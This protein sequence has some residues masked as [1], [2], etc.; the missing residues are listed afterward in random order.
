MIGIAV[1][2]IGALLFALGVF[3][4]QNW[5]LGTFGA[6]VFII[7]IVFIKSGRH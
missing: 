6:L 2:I 7:G 4:W 3:T 5:A 1:A